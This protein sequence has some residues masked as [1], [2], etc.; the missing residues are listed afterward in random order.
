MKSLSVVLTGNCPVPIRFREMWTNRKELLFQ[1]GTGTQAQWRVIDFNAFQ[2]VVCM[3]EAVKIYLS[4]DVGHC[5]TWISIPPKS[6]HVLYSTASQREIYNQLCSRDDRA[7][8]RWVRITTICENSHTSMGHA[9]RRR[10]PNADSVRPLLHWPIDAMSVWDVEMY[11]R[12]EWVL[13]YKI[14]ADYPRKLKLSSGTCG[15]TFLCG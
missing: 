9:S 11:Q 15:Q 12:F 7:S 6:R 4:K 10:L 2:I 13:V 5:I 8:S 1:T 14:S 3:Y